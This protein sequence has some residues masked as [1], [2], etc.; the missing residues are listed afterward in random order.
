MEPE[1]LF[2][3]ADQILRARVEKLLARIAV[4]SLPQFRSS[5]LDHLPNGSIREEHLLT[6][7]AHYQSMVRGV[8]GHFG[9]RG[10]G[11]VAGTMNPNTLSEDGDQSSPRRPGNLPGPHRRPGEPQGVLTHLGRG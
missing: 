4:D 10:G 11:Q 5:L 1:L 3:E 7:R 6:K 2:H 9:D 8:R